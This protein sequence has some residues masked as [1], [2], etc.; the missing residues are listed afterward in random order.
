MELPAGQLP[1]GH[2]A[3]HEHFGGFPEEPGYIDVHGGKSIAQDEPGYMDVHGG[4]R[5]E[6]GYMDIHGG[7]AGSSSTDAWA[8]SINAEEPEDVGYVD[9]HGQGGVTLAEPDVMEDSMS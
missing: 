9:V 1:V 8:H 6:P 4:A 3:H 7:A 2:D 5:D